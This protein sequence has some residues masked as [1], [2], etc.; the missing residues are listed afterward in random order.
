MCEIVA[1]TSKSNIGKI[2]QP[3][4]RKLIAQSRFNPD[5]SGYAIYFGTKAR[6]I[7]A[8]NCKKDGP[9]TKNK[10]IIAI[11][12]LEIP[13]KT[14]LLHIRHASIGEPSVVNSHPFS[15]VIGGGINYTFVHNGHLKGYKN[16]ELR[17]HE[18]EGTTD[19]ERAFCY[20]LDFIKTEGHLKNDAGYLKALHETMLAINK[21]GYFNCVITDGRNLVAYHDKDDFK[22]MFVSQQG[23]A[24]L[25]FTQVNGNTKQAILKWMDE[26]GKSDDPQDIK[27]MLMSRGILEK[28]DEQTYFPIAEGAMITPI[29]K[30]GLR[31][32]SEGVL[33]ARIA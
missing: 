6:L 13:A 7:F 5:G 30:S 12:E 10:D 20:I 28:W 9:A 15:R 23:D 8:D 17:F 27:R 14:M 4:A 33:V 29:E 2:H 26:H 31:L 1:I 24:K 19:S 18:P 32:Y 21:Q 22:S 11:S 16:L 25:I 3:F